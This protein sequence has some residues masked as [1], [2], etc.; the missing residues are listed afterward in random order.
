MY[1]LVERKFVLQVWFDPQD[2]KSM[3]CIRAEAGIVYFVHMLC[4]VVHKKCPHVCLKCYELSVFIKTPLEK[5][6]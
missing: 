6:A 2:C 3:I 5:Y 1:L 4:T